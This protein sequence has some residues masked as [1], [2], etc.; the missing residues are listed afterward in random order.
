MYDYGYD[1]GI[2]ALMGS[3]S[4]GMWLFALALSVFAIIASWKLFVKAGQPGWAALIPIYNMLVTLRVA[5]KPWWWIFLLL[6]SSVPFVGWIVSLV[7]SIMVMHGISI[8]FGK[9]SGFTVGLV[10]LPIIFISIL[11]FGSS[12][13]LANKID[14]DLDSDSDYVQM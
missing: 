9:D 12:E 2:D 1:A 7:F 5:K 4:A 3:M 13:Y 6:M 14:I 10:F 11:A 8:N